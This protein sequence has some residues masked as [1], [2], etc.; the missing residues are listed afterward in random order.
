MN[1]ITTE[2][3]LKVKHSTTKTIRSVIEFDKKLTSKSAKLTKFLW[4]KLQQYC[5][6]LIPADKHDDGYSIVSRSRLIVFGVII[7]ILVLILRL[8]FITTKDIYTHKQYLFNKKKPFS[9]L[10]IVDRNGQVL[11]N[12]IIVYD[13]Y[14]E[15]SRMTNYKEELLKIQNI[16]PNAINNKQ[17]LIERI[18]KHKEKGVVFVKRGLTLEQK[19]QLID[20]GAEG[21]FFETTE[22]RF[23]TSPSVNSITGYCP[24]LN[25]C[26]SGLEK[27]MNSYLK[28][29]DNNKLELSIDFSAQTILRDILYRKMIDTNSQGAVGL[30]MKIKTGEIMSAVSLPDCDYNQYNTCTTSAL[31]NRYSY[32]VYELGSIFKLFSSAIALQSGIDPYKKYERKEYKIGDFVIHDIDKKD[33]KGGSLNLF[34]MV[35]VSSNVGF[36]KLM[37]DVNLKDQ[38]IF[39]SNLGLLNK[40]NTELPELGK[41][42]YP[43]KWSFANAITISYG[44]GIAITPLHYITAIASLLK[45]SPVRPTF[46]K[47]N[48]NIHS[49][50]H[51]LDIDKHEIFKDVMRVVINSGAGKSAYI[52][53]YDIGGKT[54]T[55]NQ[56]K[57]GKYDKHSLILS[58]VTATPMS[59]PEYVFFLMLDK[60]YT[61]DS[62]NNINRASTILGKTMGEIISVIGPILN[63]KPIGK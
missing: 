11:A 54:G 50:Y 34:D 63:I 29:I 38:F 33:E 4:K 18:E 55:A 31:F 1:K 7:V 42:I 8:L 5:T 20:S 58:F 44:H 41:P 6:L 49:N 3:L 39:L 32:G 48:D 28:T 26:I 45:N 23:Y 56:I 35:R 43:K 22:K 36:A 12:N 16:I 60:P 14:L 59:N 53:Q 37:E 21:L 9:R 57:N 10:E 51:Y 17:D 61:D 30:I 13:L 25:K 27:S 2:K 40:L 46:L 52:D 62:N 47:S 15:P 24:D 19:Q